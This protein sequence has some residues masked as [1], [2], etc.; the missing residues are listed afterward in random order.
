M[1]TLNLSRDNPDARYFS[2]DEIKQFNSGV[3]KNSDEHMEKAPFP[4]GKTHCDCV[5]ADTRC[6]YG[7]APEMIE[8]FNPA[9]VI[10]KL[11][12]FIESSWDDEDT[13]FKY[14]KRAIITKSDMHD[15]ENVQHD[16]VIALGDNI[17][18]K[19]LK[20]K[21]LI[22]FSDLLG[23][24]NVEVSH[25][26]VTVS[27]ETRCK[28]LVVGEKCY[29]YRYG[30]SSIYDGSSLTEAVAGETNLDWLDS[31]FIFDLVK[32]MLSAEHGN[33]YDM[34]ATPMGDAFIKKIDAAAHALAQ[35][36]IDAWVEAKASLKVT[37]RREKFQQT[38]TPQ[39]S[40]VG[41]N[42]SINSAINAASA[43]STASVA[44]A[45]ATLAEVKE[46][47]SDY[48]FSTDDVDPDEGTVIVLGMGR[49][50]VV[51][52]VVNNAKGVTAGILNFVKDV[53]PVTSAA[54]SGTNFAEFTRSDIS[55]FVTRIGGTRAAT[56]FLETLGVKSRTSADD[57]SIKSISHDVIR[58]GNNAG[59][60]SAIKSVISGD[61][62]Q[63]SAED[64]VIRDCGINKTIRL[65]ESAG[66][67]VDCRVND[68]GADTVVK[69]L[70]HDNRDNPVISAA[71]LMATKSYTCVAPLAQQVNEI[72][73]A[74][75]PKRN[76]A[77]APKKA[78]PVNYIT[79]YT[80]EEIKN[81]KLTFSQD[82][83]EC[84]VKSIG[85]TRDAAE[86]LKAFGVTVQ[87]NGAGKTSNKKIAEALNSC[88]A[89][90]NVA[91]RE[92][93]ASVIKAERAA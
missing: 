69:N 57:A 66:I 45:S 35:S 15:F 28:N 36:D 6:R 8:Q 5:M 80:E 24:S 14:L 37:E 16:I 26:L 90:Q 29:S 76:S 21:C 39:Y 56:K 34:D 73:Q 27:N 81:P 75:A 93:I 85:T 82:D 49:P 86:A 65:L 18:L 13:G 3:I 11:A 88:A 77:K 17:C 7:F 59:L 12:N 40:Y 44:S 87:H 38:A 60:I 1:T 43:K 47:S 67:K 32:V 22:C 48:T 89:R 74:A 54:V 31:D 84:Y 52:S 41:K 64:M 30:Y 25:Y 92:H 79:S 23:L 72:N 19:N 70:L 61:S 53:A 33:D 62:Q 68:F 91:L 83:I 63:V 20:T 2:D 78:T 4:I 51:E 10:S 50:S 58:N 71:I 42:D 9:I 46:Q 55:K